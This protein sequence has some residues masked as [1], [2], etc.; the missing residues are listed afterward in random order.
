MTKQKLT[1]TESYPE[2]LCKLYSFKE[3]K[4]RYRKHYLPWDKINRANKKVKPV[5][6]KSFF[7]SSPTE[8]KNY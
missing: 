4:A 6:Q 5:R 1:D 8:C 7:L 3:E 2:Q